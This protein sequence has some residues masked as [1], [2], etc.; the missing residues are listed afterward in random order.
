MTEPEQQRLFDLIGELNG[1]LDSIDS[2]FADEQTRRDLS[3]KLGA[4]AVTVAEDAKRT[5]KRAMG[6]LRTIVAVVA[7]GLVIYTPLIAYGAI[8]LHERVR[9]T[10][11]PADVLVRAAPQPDHWYC[12][13]FPGTGRMTH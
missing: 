10:C 9:N 5:A 13:I 8:W 4:A 1:R 2:E 3:E 7:V 12:E 6:N 11:Y